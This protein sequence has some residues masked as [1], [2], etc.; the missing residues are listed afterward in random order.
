MQVNHLGQ[1]CRHNCARRSRDE[2][3]RRQFRMR[4]RENLSLA[5]LPPGYRESPGQTEGWLSVLPKAREKQ[6]HWWQGVGIKDL[7]SRGHFFPP[8]AIVCLQMCFH[9][10]QTVFMASWNFPNEVTFLPR[11]FFFTT[12]IGS[13]QFMETKQHDITRWGVVISDM[14]TA[15]CSRSN[16]CDL[17]RGGRI[18]PPQRGW[19][20][21]LSWRNW[22]GGRCAR[23]DGQ[24][25]A[26]GEVSP[27]LL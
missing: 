7:A 15:F 23:Q 4:T 22:E 10:M 9:Q 16:R 6:G 24:E 8:K 14:V 1:G 19:S 26:G 11:P 25:R 18:L 13:P 17:P 20:S 12:E 21:G 27:L 2:L 5:N 3:G